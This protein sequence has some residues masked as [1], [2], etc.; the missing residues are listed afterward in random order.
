MFDFVRRVLASQSSWSGAFYLVVGVVLGALVSI[1]LT[2]KAYRPRLII[3]G[4]GSG[5]SQEMHRWSVTVTNRPTYFGV[6][7]TS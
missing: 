3:S 5:G 7:F 1:Y 2:V 4:E 6:P